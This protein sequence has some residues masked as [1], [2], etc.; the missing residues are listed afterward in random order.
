MINYFKNWNKKKLN[1]NDISNK[2]SSNDVICKQILEIIG[3]KSTKI[4]LD[5]DIKNNYYVFLTNT[6]YL[7]D[8][9]KTKNGYQRICI[10]AHECIHSIQNKII[11]VV[12]FALSNIELI[13]FIIAFVCIILKFNVNMVFYS[14]LLLNIISIIP[15]LILE[16]DA[17]IRSI[18]LSKKYMKNKIDENEL[19]VIL[20]IYKHQ[21]LIFMPMFI[22][23]LLI[24]RIIRLMV[25]CIII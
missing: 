19:N 15:R 10:I 21:I 5:Q 3:N 25:L 12:N 22:I 8:K 2:F 24:G 7:S 20:N 18:D 6:I 14:Y 1:L 23:S 4:K 11:Q 16:I 13:A 17:T 9:E